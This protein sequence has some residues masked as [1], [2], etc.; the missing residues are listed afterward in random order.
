MEQKGLESKRERDKGQRA[1]TP[2]TTGVKEQSF[3]AFR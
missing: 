1:I 2:A 3:S